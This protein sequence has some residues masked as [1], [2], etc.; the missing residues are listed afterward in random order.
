M[1]NGYFMVGMFIIAVLLL[2]VVC[3]SGKYE[4]NVTDTRVYG[5][6]P[7]KQVDLP[8]DSVSSVSTSIFDGIAVGTS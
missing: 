2:I 6:T 1:S 7:F 3:L 4:F 5:K 8:L